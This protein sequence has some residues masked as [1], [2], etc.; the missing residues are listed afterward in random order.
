M[1]FGGGRDLL[2]Q[3]VGLTGPLVQLEG[4]VQVAKGRARFE[5]ERLALDGDDLKELSALGGTLLHVLTVEL[6]LLRSAH[7]VDIDRAALRVGRAPLGLFLRGGLEAGAGVGVVVALEHE[8]D[9]VLVE[10]RLPKFADCDVV[11]PLADA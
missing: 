7:G 10:D 6:V 2:D 8:V 3:L 4:I 1:P 5:A 11:A 9:V